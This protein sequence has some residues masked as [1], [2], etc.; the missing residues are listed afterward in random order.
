MRKPLKI[1]IANAFRLAEKIQPL[2]PK[3]K[4]KK[5]A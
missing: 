4:A 5:T 1:K 3:K 2:P